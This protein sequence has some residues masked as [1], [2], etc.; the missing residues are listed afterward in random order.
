MGEH[1]YFGDTERTAGE[2]L[3]CPALF[4]AETMF[5][6]GRRHPELLALRPI[7]SAPIEADLAPAAMLGWPRIMA[8]HCHVDEQCE[9]RFRFVASHLVASNRAVSQID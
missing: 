4:R 3:E 8:K 7:I 6:R 9:N 2:Q 5:S 1:I